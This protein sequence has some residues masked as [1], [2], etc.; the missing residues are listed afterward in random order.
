MLSTLGDKPGAKWQGGKA[1]A[2]P[3]ATTWALLEHTTENYPTTWAAGL[4][5]AIRIQECRLLH[6]RH[7]F[8][9]K[10]VVRKTAFLLNGP[11]LTLH[12]LSFSF[13]GFRVLFPFQ[14][15]CLIFLDN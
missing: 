9:I 5:E 10:G 8:L 14:L 13:R 11:G 6:A 4:A 2:P 15:R 3:V 7:H 1:K 12:S